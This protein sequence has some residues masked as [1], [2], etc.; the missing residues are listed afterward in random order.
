M[1][2]KDISSINEQVL[3]RGD[4]FGL[5][6]I[7]HSS[8]FCTTEK[9]FRELIQ[10]VKKLIPF[11]FA[12][13]L[14]GNKSGEDVVARYELINISYPDEWLYY[15]VTKKFHLIDPIVRENFANYSLQ[16]WQD[17]YR[18]YGPPK[19][20]IKDA[21]DFNLRKGYSIGLRN[22]SA[23]EGSLFSFAGNSIEH[24]TRTQAVLQ[25]LAPHLHRAFSNLLSHDDKKTGPIRLTPREKEILLWVKE[26]KS[27]W[28]ISK[29]LFISQDTVKFHM[30]NIFHKLNTT[31]RSH[32]IAIA[33][34]CKLIEF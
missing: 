29:I 4:A 20:F 12:A 1:I 18:K 3:S 24:S 19:T 25:C 15:Y 30:K 6:D 14:M 16:F 7:I 23:T 9:E 34:G 17:T 26:G 31:N 13:C 2:F 28:D 8:I 21:E 10:D 11:D 22:L 32:A 27:N 5:L 33:L